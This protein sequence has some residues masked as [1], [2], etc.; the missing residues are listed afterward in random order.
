MALEVVDRIE[1]AD[2]GTV[3]LVVRDAEAAEDL[4]AYYHYAAAPPA[5]SGMN[6]DQWAEQIAAHALALEARSRGVDPPAK[7]HA[8][9]G[10]L[11]A[12][13]EASGE[14]S[15]DERAELDQAR[16]AQASADQVARDRAELEQLRAAK[17]GGQPQA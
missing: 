15:A 10:E 7:A 8:N 9:P 1:N 13:P 6:A 14:L 17:Q 16:A 11:G 3:T 5:H 4:G 2:T 12:A